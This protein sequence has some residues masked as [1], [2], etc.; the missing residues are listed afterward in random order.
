MQDP[1]PW[2][3]SD[4]WVLVVLAD[5]SCLTLCH[6][7]DCSP[8][9]SYVMEFSRQEY[10]CGL[11]SVSRGSSWSRDWTQVSHIAGRFVTIWTTREACDPW[12]GGQIRLLIISR[13]HWTFSSLAL[14][15]LIFSC[16]MHSLF[17]PQSS[18]LPGKSGERSL[19]LWC[20]C[21]NSLYCPYHSQDRKSVV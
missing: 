18:I 5:Q 20:P 6:P 8:L 21:C 3:G 1:S 10:W 16:G 11:S 7:M 9:G 2:Q 13:T 19:L 4:P 12:R 17:I 15:I 14:C